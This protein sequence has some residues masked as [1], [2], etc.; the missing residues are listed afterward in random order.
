M[1][2]Q[3]SSDAI[4]LNPDYLTGLMPIESYWS[5]GDPPQ[6]EGEWRGGS[7]VL[8]DWNGNGAYV[9]SPTQ[10]LRGWTGPAAPQNSSDQLN[11]L[12]GGSQ[13]IWLQPGSAAP[14]APMPSPWK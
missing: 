6:T 4:W 12:P 7:A 3:P 9:Q 1:T 2:K 8:N 11:V 14:S 13:Q 5:P 10:G